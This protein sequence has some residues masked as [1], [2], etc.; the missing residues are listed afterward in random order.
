MNYRQ[1]GTKFK[2]GGGQVGDRVR[3][4]GRR[5]SAVPGVSTHSL[6]D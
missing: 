6:C 4:Q 5:L 3:L 2:G 1:I